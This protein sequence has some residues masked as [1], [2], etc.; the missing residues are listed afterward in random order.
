M[1]NGWTWIRPFSS[2]AHL[3]IGYSLDVFHLF[4]AAFPDFQIIPCLREEG[5][6]GKEQL[7]I[8]Y[9]T[10]NSQYSLDSLD[11]EPGKSNRI[12]NI[13]QGISN[14]QVLRRCI[15]KSNI[16]Y[17]KPKSNIQVRGTR[18][19]LCASAGDMSA[20]C[21]LRRP[22]PILRRSGFEGQASR[23][24]RGDA[25]GAS[26]VACHGV[27]RLAA[28]PP[29]CYQPFWN[30]IFFRVTPLMARSFRSRAAASF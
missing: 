7:N 1:V 6:L 30:D 12:S 18:R 22:G 16:T 29:A 19:S 25:A 5:L 11:I 28:P 15:Q 17:P 21:F 26:T 23:T 27:A 3:D 14:V 4:S 13:Q 24:P 8:Q 2:L 20:S 9:P 10:R